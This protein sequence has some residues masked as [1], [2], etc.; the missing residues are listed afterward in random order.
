MTIPKHPNL[1]GYEH[2]MAFMIT[3]TATLRKAGERPQLSEARGE[4]EDVQVEQHIRLTVFV[5]SV[6]GVC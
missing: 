1:R 4:A 6:P 3:Q 2:R 5:Y